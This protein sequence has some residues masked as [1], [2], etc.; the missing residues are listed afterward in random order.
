MVSVRKLPVGAIPLTGFVAIR[1]PFMQGR[2]AG[3]PCFQSWMS[4]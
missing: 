2:P 4:L 3:R 1:C